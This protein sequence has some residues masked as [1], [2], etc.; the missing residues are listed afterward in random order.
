MAVKVKQHKGK[1]WVFIDHKGK[2]KAKC[3]GKSEKAAKE[4]AGKIE[5][6]LKLGDFSPLEEEE[7]SLLLA[8]YVAQW[9]KT[10]AAV[11]C[12]PATAEEYAATC[13]LHL[14]PAFGT[15]PLQ[16]VSREDVKHLVAQKLAQ[17]LSRARIRAILSL[18]RAIYNGAIEDRHVTV[19]PAARLGRL[20][21]KTHQGKEVIPL[22]KEELRL[23]L[24][25]LQEHFPAYYP[26]FL[27]LARTGIRLG[28]ALALKWE[29]VDWHGGFIEIRR[30]FRK[31]RISTP[32]SHKRRRVDMSNQL[33]DTLT[34]LLEARKGEA[35]QR[36]WQEVPAWVFCSSTGTL[37]NGSH[38]LNRVLR[39]AYV[40]A[41]LRLIRIHDLRHTYASLLIQQGESLAYLKE[42]LGHHSI[43]MTV[44]IYGH[45]VPGSNRQAVDRLD[46]PPSPP[47]PATIR[48]PDATTTA[49]TVSPPMENTGE[50]YEIP[51][52]GEEGTANQKI[53]WP[54]PSAAS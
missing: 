35:W 23:L 40:R 37:L 47:P 41:G 48:N 11:H 46:D 6:R 2:R 19:N 4:V 28:E 36:G 7:Q 39:P 20:L 38:L 49:N 13:R 54:V 8:D 16:S 53:A 51:L 1:W 22:T 27:T 32:K 52:T 17:G 21:T 15:K 9:L 42:Q 24:A 10:Y 14:L 50:D 33:A 26:F 25:T 34:A 18:L 30:N 5:A 3:I 12:K 31:R 43:Q 29:D 44:D 45:L